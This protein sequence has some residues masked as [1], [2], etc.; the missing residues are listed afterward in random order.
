MY[1]LTLKNIKSQVTGSPDIEHHINQAA[2]NVMAILDK[3]M[4]PREYLK[5]CKAVIIREIASF[6]SVISA[7]SSAVTGKCSLAFEAQINLYIIF[8]AWSVISEQLTSCKFSGGW[9]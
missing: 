5:S 6:P 3:Q 7:V 8:C 1:D 4:T 9:K 2:E